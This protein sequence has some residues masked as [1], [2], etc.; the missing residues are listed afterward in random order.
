MTLSAD[1]DLPYYEQ[2]SPGTGAL[3]P[4]AA[5]RSSAPRLDLGG[6]WRFRLSPTVATAEEHDRRAHFAADG[7]D[8]ADWAE[9]TVPGHWPLQ[10]HGAPAY[11]NHRYPFP[12]DPPRVPDENPTGDHRLVFDLPA[13]WPSDGGA[14]LRFEGVE[15]CCRVWLNGQELG[16]SRGSRLPVEFDAAP[17]LRR[18]GN[19]LAV[20]VHQWSSGS[21]L[22][23]Q[24]MWWLPGVFREVTLQ[25]RPDGGVRDLFVHAGWDHRT[26]LGTLR[27]DADPGALLSIPELGIADLPAGRSVTAAVDPWTAETPRLY[28]AVL[29]APG[30]RVA[31]RIGFRTVAVVDG[32]LTV[33]GRRILLR[34]VNRH[35][36]HPDHGRALPFEAMR[37]DLL[38]MKRHNINA[39]RT[40]HYPP[41]PAF[42]DLC[43]ELGLWVVDECDLETHGFVE[44]GWR[45]N[46]V[47]DP[48]WTPAL[49]DRAA[50]MVER[51]K[52]HPAVIMWSLG[53]ECGTGRGLG[54]MADWIRARDPG[55]PI[56]YEGDRS[57]RDTDVYSRMYASHQEVQAIGGRTEEPLD[58]PELD[59]R[60]RTLPFVLC[61]YAHAMGNGPGGLSEYQDLFTAHDR[62]QGGFVWEWIDHGIRQRGADG[63][64]W[65]AYGGDFGEELHDGNFVCDGL[66]LP[67]RTPS[68]GLTEFKAVVQPVGLA[69]DAGGVRI[70][71]GHDFADLGRLAFRWVHQVDGE[72]TGEGLLPVPVLM[73]GESAE[74]K[75]PEP[76]A[77]RVREGE[78][79]WTV[80]AVLAEGTAWADAGHEVAWAQFPAAPAPTR[81]A[82]RPTA[83]PHREPAVLRL[84]PGSFD[85]VTGLLRTLG[86]LTVL[87]PRLDVWRAPTDNDEMTLARPQDRL[88]GQW[89]RLGLHRMRHRTDAVRVE[90]GELLVRTRVAPAATDA[91]LRT[92]Y[93][94]SSDGVRLR[95]LVEV[96]PEGEWPVPLPRVG[97]RLAVPAALGRV[98]WF[99]G[100]PGEAYPDSRRAARIGSW[101][102]TVDALQTPYVMPQENGSR[103]GVRKASLYDGAGGGLRIEGEPEFALTARRWT[104]EQLAAARHT[105]DLEPDPEW[106]H[107]NLDHAHHGLGSASCGPGVL[108]AHRLTV[109]PFRFAVTFS[110]L[111]PVEQP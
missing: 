63:R 93:R 25:H 47:D 68:P 74:L 88:A 82:L 102:S 39:V 21:Y 30:E 59:A 50:R 94:W 85:P 66:L 20:R 31:L 51:D 110:A 13:D 84:G 61:E 43:D 57:C 97:V 75:L 104:T 11:T 48:R 69:G 17:L 32:V 42:L 56:H 2:Y 92:V 33:N 95:L 111:G 100:G 9:I 14:V 10:G 38:L 49:L 1:H 12:V 106:I 99:G 8:D 40:S 19:V 81:P 91:G 58:D 44:T 3:P 35:E 89:R 55:R 87:G 15:S 37:Q 53:N 4:R 80:S 83:V 54:A 86:G 60:R 107:L 36:W 79:W 41:H 22:E 29:A 105:A 5:F 18:S 26:G 6:R 67:D 24:D 45:G 71:N 73:P 109:A 62:C 90:D 23:D 7:H 101:E 96:E 46:P 70:T 52:N 27:V 16:V 72:T 28:D 65:F 77:D 78:A 34:G 76:P 103:T 108:P 64:E 98:R